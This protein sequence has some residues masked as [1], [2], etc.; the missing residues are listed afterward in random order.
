MR[1]HSSSTCGQGGGGGDVNGLGLHSLVLTRHVGGTAVNGRRARA[2]LA[3]ADS[4][5]GRGRAPGYAL[6]SA[7][8]VCFVISTHFLISVHF[9]ESTVSH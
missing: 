2:A 4:A 3:S 6:A 9:P 1:A 8:S 7:D 5:C